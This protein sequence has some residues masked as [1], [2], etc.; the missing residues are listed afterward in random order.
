M[1]AKDRAIQRV[2]AYVVANVA[3]LLIWYRYGLLLTLAVSMVA[4]AARTLA[5]ADAHKD[6]EQEQL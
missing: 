1:T 2:L 5:R 3:S 6:R 4:G